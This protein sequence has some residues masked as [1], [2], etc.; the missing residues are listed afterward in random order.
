MKSKYILSLNL[1]TFYSLCIIFFTVLL[2]CYKAN[3][4]LI[5]IV[6]SNFIALIINNVY[7]GIS[8]NDICKSIDIQDFVIPRIGF[9]QFLI[10]NITSMIFRISIYTFFVLLYGIILFGNSDFFSITSIWYTVVL[11]T[12]LFIEEM[13]ILQQIVMGKNNAHILVSILLNLIMHYCIIIPSL[14]NIR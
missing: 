12:S 10:C 6:S 8:N 2:F 5:G 7:L 4:Y 11:I 13:I 3:S 9:K 14:I 1:K